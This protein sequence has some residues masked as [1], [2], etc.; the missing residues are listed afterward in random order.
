M[1]TRINQLDTTVKELSSMAAQKDANI[2][3]L[4]LALERL[5]DV[6]AQLGEQRHQN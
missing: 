5:S 2:H 1:Q 3:E 6:E 4:Q